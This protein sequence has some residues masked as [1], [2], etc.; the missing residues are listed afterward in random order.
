MEV[1]R[2][3]VLVEPFRENAPGPHVAAVIDALERAGLSTE[4]GPFATT[5]TGSARDVATAA[6]A[7]IA[8]GFAAGATAVQI[9]VESVVAAADEP[10]DVSER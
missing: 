10:V 9:R 5:A 7:M 3:E 2:V 1:V 8:A 6:E 4:M